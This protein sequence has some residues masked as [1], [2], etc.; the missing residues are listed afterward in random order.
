MKFAGLFFF[1]TGHLAMAQ[2]SPTPISN[3]YIANLYDTKLGA[4][5][6]LFTGVGFVD[7][8]SQKQ[9]EGNYYYEQN[10]WT[11]GKVGIRGQIYDKVILRFNL[12]TNQ[13]IIQNQFTG[14]SIL[15]QQEKVDFFEL[16]NTRFV[17]LT[18]PESGYYAELNS[19]LVK[20]YAQ[21]TCKGNEKIINNRLVLEFI[22]REKY[23]I[24]K[25]GI[26]HPVKSRSS[27]LKILATHKGELKKK[28]REEGIIFS[29]QKE[30]A[31]STMAAYFD[32]LQK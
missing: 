19:G 12:M 9:T 23:F 30:K 25:D 10:E 6:A 8:I 21:Y 4:N 17:Y 15:V 14:E 5:A 22:Q 31:L 28:L 1:L 24:N 32:Q 11:T 2:T 29:S 26:M 16:H 3:H 18:K 13:L 7:E 27:A 20:A